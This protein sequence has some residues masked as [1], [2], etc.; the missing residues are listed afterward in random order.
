MADAGTRLVPPGRAQITQCPECKGAPV[1]TAPSATEPARS[2]TGHARA[3]AISP[4]TTSTT[5]GNG[6]PHQLR[7][8]MER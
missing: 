6:L 2:S 1:S 4:G 5:G 7:L 8:P 3:A